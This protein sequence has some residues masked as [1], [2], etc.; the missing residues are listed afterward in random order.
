MDFA[1]VVMVGRIFPGK[2]PS[3]LHVVNSRGEYKRITEWEAIGQGEIQARPL[4]EKN[5]ND[6]MTMQDFANLCYSVIKYIENEHLDESVGTRND[7]PS[8]KYLVD[9]TEI[10]SEPKNNELNRFKNSYSQYAR[11]I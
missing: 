8:I 9:D 11:R 7:E 4:I 2:V 1:L 5:W 3:D 10:D 6:D